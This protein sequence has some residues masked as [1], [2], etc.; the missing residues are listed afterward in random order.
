MTTSVLTSFSFFR[1][2]CSIFKDDD[3]TVN[4]K[5]HKVLAAGLNPILCIGETKDEYELGLNK[6]VRDMI[7]IYR[8]R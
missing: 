6:L 5:L 3:A 8:Y 7:D 2:C 4:K 1:T